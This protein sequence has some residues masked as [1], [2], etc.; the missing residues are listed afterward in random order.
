[1]SRGA[2]KPAL[3]F[4]TRS[5]TNWP[6]QSQKLRAEVEEELYYPCNEIKG[7]DQLRSYCEAD[8]MDLRLYFRVPNYPV[9]SRYGSHEAR[10]E[11]AYFQS[12]KNYGHYN[13]KNV[14]FK[15]NET[16]YADEITQIKS[17][18]KMSAR[19]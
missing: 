12:D 5:D 9:F 16:K 17:G 18:K 7:A 14:R 15:L 10:R 6:V 11:K 8:L 19:V 13:H 3:G 1:M 4:L 2:R